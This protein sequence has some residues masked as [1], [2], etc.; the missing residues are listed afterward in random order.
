MGVCTKERKGV[1]AEVLM[2]TPCTNSLGGESGGHSRKLKG[3]PRVGQDG[4]QFATRL[5]IARNLAV[6]QTLCPANARGHQHC[7]RPLTTASDCPSA[8]WGVKSKL[9]LQSNARRRRTPQ[10][11]AHGD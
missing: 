1:A 3:Q 6:L 10:S 2:A 7:V 11:N 8:S 9:P 5:G 4:L